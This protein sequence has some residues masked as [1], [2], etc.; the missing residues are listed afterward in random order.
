MPSKQVAQFLWIGPRLSLIEQL[1]LRSFVDIGYQVHLY[2]YE[3]VQGVPVEAT[4]FDA[5][6]IIPRD[7]VFV[8]KSGFGAGSFAGFAD[9]FRYH[10]LAQKGG[11]WFDSDFVALHLMPEPSD[12]YFASTWEFKWGS[13]ANNCAIWA[14]PGDPYII[15]LRDRCE[16]ILQRKGDTVRFG[17]TGPHLVQSLVRDFDLGAHVAPFWEFCP[18]PWQ[19]VDRMAY[20]NTRAWLKDRARFIRH[21]A[22]Q[23]MRDEF[24]AAYLRRGTRAVHLH[25]EVWRANGLSKDKIYHWGSLVGSLQRKHGFGV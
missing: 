22:R 17:E 8:Y 13:C 11:W 24:R 23:A 2:V 21:V 15:E 3:D 5:N 12:V 7:E 16:A 10:L 1:C 18:Y 20:T 6:K 19:M 9:R 25:N 14:R 4:V